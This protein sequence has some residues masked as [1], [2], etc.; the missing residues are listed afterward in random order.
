[1]DLGQYKTTKILGCGSYGKVF[2]G[3]NKTTEQSVA[4]KMISLYKKSKLYVEQVEHEINFLKIVSKSKYV[5]NYIDDFHFTAG[6]TEYRIIIMEDLSLWKNVYNYIQDL[7]DKKQEQIPQK[8]LKLIIINL[9]LGLEHLHKLGIAHRDIKPENLMIDDLFNIKYIDFGH[10][11]SINVNCNNDVG[12][13]L[14][15]SPEMSEF[16]QNNFKLTDYKNVTNEILQ[17]N[18]DNAMNHDI[19]SLGLILYQLSNIKNFPNNMP[20]DINFDNTTDF[21]HHLHGNH[22]KYVS[23]YSHENNYSDLDFNKLINFILSYDP[24]KRPSIFDIITYISDY[25]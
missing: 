18:L 24:K 1:M 17:K 23:S 10:A 21:F 25:I 22:N 13:P 7:N 8:N 4:I 5:V 12:T 2:K 15:M 14:Y 9:I 20:F 6:K 11:G 19:W 3:I 16:V